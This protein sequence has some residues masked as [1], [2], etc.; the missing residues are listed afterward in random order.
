MRTRPE[1]A[2]LISTCH[3]AFGHPCRA[4]DH[5]QRKEPNE[6]VRHSS[7]LRDAFEGCESHDAR[8]LS[9]ARHADS[10]WYED[11]SA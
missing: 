10:C 4:M 3:D 7:G 2:S 5:S 11:R 6:D 9:F 8:V 1:S